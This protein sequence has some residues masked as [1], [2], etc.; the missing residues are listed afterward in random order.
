VPWKE[1]ARTL[2]PPRL[3][4]P[5]PAHHHLS[6]EREREREREREIPRYAAAMK[7]GRG[8]G[9]RGATA[10]RPVEEEERGRGKMARDLEAPSAAAV[11]HC[12]GGEGKE[13]PGISGS[14]GEMC[15]TSGCTACYH[16]PPSDV[17][18]TVVLLRW[19]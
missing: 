13:R 17:P 9:S 15:S 16:A 6:G 1:D 12:W 18:P 11:R 8:V 19:C 5:P 4:R 2:S 14:K 3:L 7:R 10:V